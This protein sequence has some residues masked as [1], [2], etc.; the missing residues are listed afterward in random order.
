MNAPRKIIHIDCDCFYASV[1]MRD[2][3]SLRDVP[4]AI[5]GAADRRGVIATCN[6]PARTFGVRSAMPTSRA[7]RLCPT[8]VLLPP[9]FERYRAASRAVH[10]I[11]RD[12]TDRI[13]PLSLDEAYLDVTGCDACHGSATLIAR[14]IRARIEAEVGITASAGV[15]GNKLIAKIASDWNKPNGQ[16]V[17]TPAEVDAF[18]SPLPVD[19]LWGVGK[20]TAQR[21]HQLGLHTCA[22]LRGWSQQALVTR[23]GKLGRSLY[24]QCRGDDNRPV[25][26]G[27]RRKSLSVEHTYPRDLPALDDCLAQLPRLLADFTQRLAR[28]DPDEPPHKAFVKIKYHD[29]TQTTMECVCAA[30]DAAVFE[31][32]LRDAWPRGQ[33]PVRLL[34]IGVRFADAAPV[35]DPT[36]PLWLGDEPVV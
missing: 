17:V 2:D 20:V 15:A 33:R 35:T 34:G 29:F 16:L 6:Y 9:D 10:R 31:R 23:F 12:Y 21:L 1:E 8:L 26:G 3:P 32:L 36:L 5:G 18:I 22:D 11:F 25:E 30:P 7:L 13:E 24:H 14:E 19:K 28:A 4:L 27:G